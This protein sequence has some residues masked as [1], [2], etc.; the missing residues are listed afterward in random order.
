LSYLRELPIDELKLDRRFI[1]P[2]TWDPR[3]AEIVR[4]V[5]GLA[6]ILGLRTVAEGVEDAETADRLRAYACDVAQGFHYSPPLSPA[7]ME[8]LL[9]AEA[10]A[11]PEPAAARSS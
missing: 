7:A 10:T 9:R 11:G 4:A 6:Q 1:G 5:I 8:A 2:I 3:A